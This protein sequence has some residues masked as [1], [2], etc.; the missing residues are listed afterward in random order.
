MMASAFKGLLVVKVPAAQLKDAKIGTAHGKAVLY[1]PSRGW[2]TFWVVHNGPEVT[3]HYT[4][5]QKEQPEGF[6]EGYG[7]VWEPYNTAKIFGMSAEA[8]TIA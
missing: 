4:G 6:K 1:L 2:Y 5:P 7:G 8:I 3:Q